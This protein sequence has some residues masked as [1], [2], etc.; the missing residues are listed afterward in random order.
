[1]AHQ[2]ENNNIPISESEST[3]FI[4]PKSLLSKEVSKDLCQ[5]PKIKYFLGYGSMDKT[6]K[7]INDEYNI[8]KRGL[9][10]RRLES[11]EN[12]VIVCVPAYEQEGTDLNTGRKL[13]FKKDCVTDGSRN[14][15][16]S[17]L[18]IGM[19]EDECSYLLL[20]KNE[21]QLWCLPSII[22]TFLK[23]HKISQMGLSIIDDKLNV[24]KISTRNTFN[25]KS[26]ID[27]NCEVKV[28]P[29][30]GSEFT[31]KDNSSQKT[32]L[33][34]HSEN[35]S[36]EDKLSKSYFTKYGIKYY[37]NR[38]YLTKNL[39]GDMVLIRSQGFTKK[40]DNITVLLGYAIL[41]DE[42]KK[43]LDELQRK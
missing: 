15:S 35:V 9:L 5:Y 2:T 21:E 40:S 34:I 10:V 43:S 12:N 36:L 38:C 29:V 32:E 23:M 24:I 31:S 30:T 25:N 3:P 4:L 26:K 37:L 20:K 14:W 19:D 17:E 8:T 11:G 7:I 22:T 27:W 39:L 28:I 41:S 33:F 18:I 42:Q 1:M 16:Y 13:F 6:G